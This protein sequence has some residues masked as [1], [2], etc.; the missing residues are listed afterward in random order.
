MEFNLD[1]FELDNQAEQQPEI[2]G[3]KIGLFTDIEQDEYR[4]I[5]ALAN[6]DAIMIENNPADYIW[7]RKAPINHSKVQTKDFGT[8]LHCALLEPKQYDDLIIV[9]SVKGRQTKAFE[10][11]VIDNPNNIVLTADEAE[12]IKVMVGSVNAHPTAAHLLSLAGETECSVIANDNDRNVLLKCRPDKN[13]VESLGLCLDVK[14]TGNLDDWRSDREWINPLYKFDYGHQAAFYMH[15]LSLH[16]GFEVTKFTFIAVSSSIALGRYEVGVFDVTK[17]QL[18][19][20]GFWQRMTA[21]IERYKQC[22]DSNDWLHSETFNFYSEDDYSD[23]VEVVFD[24]E[25][26]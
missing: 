13:M 17:D 19:A 14:S 4:A 11:E 23:D 25:E 3:P 2:K 9:S 1:D 26:Q 21:N 12:Q 8:A 24:G 20:W 18:I 22:L 16:Y 15:V 7:S 5:D 6:S 10:Q